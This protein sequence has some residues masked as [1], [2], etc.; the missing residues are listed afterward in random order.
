MHFFVR[1]LFLHPFT[2]YTSVCH[3][4]GRIGNL[5]DT[6]FRQLCFFVKLMLNNVNNWFYTTNNSDNEI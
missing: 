1:K 4:Q 6:V 5:E 3:V 2:K